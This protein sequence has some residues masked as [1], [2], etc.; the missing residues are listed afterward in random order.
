[1]RMGKSHKGT[2]KFKKMLLKILE[3]I[4]LQFIRDMLQ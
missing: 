1:M 2:G 4:S 3:V